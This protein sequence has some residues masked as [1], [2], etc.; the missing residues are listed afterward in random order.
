MGH[1]L[2]VF[3]A[4]VALNFGVGYMASDALYEDESALQGEVQI[5]E[6]NTQK[7]PKD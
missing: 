2:A 5:E 4:L 1:V 6:I 3:G 7:A